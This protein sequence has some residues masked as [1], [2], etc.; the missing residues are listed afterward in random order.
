MSKN[1][2]HYLNYKP[3]GK[4]AAIAA[5]IQNGSILLG[6]REYREAKGGASVWTAPGGSVDEGETLEQA[7]RRETKE[8]TGIADL[9]FEDYIGLVDA[10]ERDPLY[11]FHCHT[12]T[13]PQRAEPD[14]FSEWRWFSLT[15][16]KAGKPNSYI[17]EMSRSVILDYCRNNG[18][19]DP[20]QE[21]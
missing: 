15:E 10:S 20:Q 7:V 6:L 9:H 13:D 8:E 12:D 16:F 3:E 2:K 19:I 11:V 21:S 17:N 4:A 14:K 5:I 1:A 18:I